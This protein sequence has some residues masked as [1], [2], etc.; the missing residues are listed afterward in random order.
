MRLHF[1]ELLWFSTYAELRAE[2]SRSYLGLLWWLVEPALMMAA[3]WL[4]FDRILGSGGPGY[5]PFLLIG[6]VVWQWFKSS[7]VHAGQAIWM[8]LVLIHQVRVPVLIF[9]FVHLLADAIKFAV[10]FVVLLAVLWLAG[11][12]PNP[13]YLSLPLLLSCIGLCAVGGGLLLAA[14]MPLLPDLRFVVEQLLAVLMFLSGIVFAFERVPAAYAPWLAWNPV[15]VLVD[16]LRGVLLHGRWPDPAALL[17]VAVIAV[18][19]ALAGVAAVR[20]LAARYPK[21]AA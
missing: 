1:L 13:A 11:Y 16:A 4:V 20:R 18:A 14:L 5:L 21:L 19:L 10:V 2:R 17:R 3:F 8:N 12:P 9:P 15:L 6:L 7:V